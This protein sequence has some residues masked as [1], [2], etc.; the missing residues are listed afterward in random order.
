MPP[1]SAVVPGARNVE[2]ADYTHYTFLLHP[3]GW[4]S[5]FDLLTNEDTP[6]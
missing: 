5:V 4:S 6:T 3:D 1:E 2:V